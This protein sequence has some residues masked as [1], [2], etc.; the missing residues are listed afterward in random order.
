[1]FKSLALL[2]ALVVATATMAKADQ[3]SINGSDVVDTTAQTLT[4]IG[5]S[6]SIGYPLGNVGF[7]SSTGIFSAF[8][9]CNEC[10]EL[11]KY[12]INYGAFTSPTGLFA[13]T[14]GSNN[15][16]VTLD[17][18]T[19]WSATDNNF[20]IYGDATINLNGVDTN[21]TLILTSQGGSG[22]NTTFSATTSPVPEPASLALFGSGL[23]GIV[24]LA[25]RKF[26]V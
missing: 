13:I 12:P 9:Y 17:S 10:V 6:N 11:Q 21:G 14:N 5:P 15:L 1:M 19:S 24:G 16:F 4:F 18:I 26:N 25:R 7:D 8:T 23:L 3:I 2:T 22:I 20:T